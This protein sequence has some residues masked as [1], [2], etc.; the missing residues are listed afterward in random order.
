MDLKVIGSMS[1]GQCAA[2][3]VKNSD[4]CCEI[5]YVTLSG[6]CK[7]GPSGCCHTEFNNVSGS[8]LLHTS[9]KF[10]DYIYTLSVTNGGVFGDWT[11]Q[12][13]CTKGHYAIGYKMRIEG[14][15]ADSSELNAIEMICGSRGGVRC[16]DTA[17]SG[18]QK[19]GDWT[20]EALCP[21]RTLLVAF[22]LQVHQ[23]NVVESDNTGANYVKFKCR[24]FKDDVSDFDLS[25]PPGYGIYG[26][27]GEWSDACPVNS[28]I[29]GI[30][31]KIHPVQGGGAD[32]TA[33]N[34]V[35]FFCCE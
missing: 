21:A 33:L 5:T 31:T 8:N 3:C 2:F 30:Q 18:Q 27:Y 12:E 26:T 29:C 13:F 19:W 34:D 25:Y 6:E 22:S 32:D 14:P 11:Y 28:A 24:Y 10:S 35:K 4:N 17:S 9:R 23:Y 7:L 15:H 1:K 16:G 20:E